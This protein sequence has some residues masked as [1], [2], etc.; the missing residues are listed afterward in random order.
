MINTTKKLLFNIF[1]RMVYIFQGSGLGNIP[2]VMAIYKFTLR[3]LGPSEVNI[4]GKNMFIDTG[5]SMSL[6]VNGSISSFQK[7]ILQDE[8]NPGDNVVTVGAHIGYF[9]LEMSTLV[10]NSGKVFAFEPHPDNYKLLVKNMKLNNC[11]NVVTEQ[12]AVSNSSGKTHLSSNKNSLLNRILLKNDLYCDSDLLSVKSIRLDDYFKNYKG[13][14]NLLM[15]DVEGAE[16]F[17][18]DGAKR[19]IHKNRNIKIVLEFCPKQMIVY[20]IDPTVMLDKISSMGFKLYDINEDKK[21]L[22][23]KEI[24]EFINQYSR[25][26]ITNILCKRS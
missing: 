4:E 9:E 3:F 14:L 17:V 1:K 8:I 18:I 20:G 6:S 21:K 24:S 5:D 15:I 2:F 13:K 26:D 25:G 10:G 19:I 11:K 22:E 23:C 16:S 12:L 7:K